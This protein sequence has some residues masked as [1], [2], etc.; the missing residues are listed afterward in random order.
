MGREGRKTEVNMKEGEPGDAGGQARLDSRC[1]REK[2][3]ARGP[4]FRKKKKGFA[5][6]GQMPQRRG[7]GEINEKENQANPQVRTELPKEEEYKHR[8]NPNQVWADDER[9]GKKRGQGRRKRNKRCRTLYSLKR[10][11]CSPSS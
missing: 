5:E 9:K 10:W 8:R 7:E 2:L 11:Q 3:L 6:R 4:R 1:K